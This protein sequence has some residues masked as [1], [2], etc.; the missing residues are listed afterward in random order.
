MASGRFYKSYRLKISR[1]GLDIVGKQS[2]LCPDS[3]RV[4]QP[5]GVGQSYANT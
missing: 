1:R 4:A 2:S 5:L 3:R